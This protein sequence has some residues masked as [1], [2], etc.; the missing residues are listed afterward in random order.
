M[1][2]KISQNQFGN[3]RGY[4]N[5]SWTELGCNRTKAKF[6]LADRVKEFP[7]AV[8]SPKSYFQLHDIY[9]HL[10]DAGRAGKEHIT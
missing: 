2:I 9:Y 7:G 5:G 8:I 4:C 1:I 6:W 3:F 10:E